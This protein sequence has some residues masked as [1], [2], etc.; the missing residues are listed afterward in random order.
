M[1]TVASKENVIFL[2]YF[3]SHSKNNYT[4]VFGFHPYSEMALGL[5]EHSRF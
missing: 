4:L 5:Q 1:K 3:I 2:C